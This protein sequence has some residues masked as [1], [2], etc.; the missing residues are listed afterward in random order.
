MNNCWY[1][2]PDW[3]MVI[4]T[5]VTGIV[6]AIATI[7]FG[8]KQYRLSKEQKRLQEEQNRQMRAAQV[9]RLKNILVDIQHNAEIFPSNAAQLLQFV[10]VRTQEFLY[11][12][13]GQNYTLLNNL[14][15]ELMREKRF[16]TILNTSEDCQN[17]FRNLDSMIQFELRSWQA[18]ASIV[19]KVAPE[20]VQ[21]RFQDSFTR[22]GLSNNPN[23][24]L[25]L[26]GLVFDIIEL[27]PS[28]PYM[29]QFSFDQFVRFLQSVFH[30]DG[31]NIYQTIDRIVEQK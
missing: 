31:D 18:L 20:K 14:R 26:C 22:R 11:R 2:N 3:W 24:H 15:N 10:D 4:A 19:V 29:A 12:D 17:H 6:M 25:A 1:S 16:A 7:V 21:Q 8:I 5:S 23:D 27:D 30:T 9:A 13:A 28:N